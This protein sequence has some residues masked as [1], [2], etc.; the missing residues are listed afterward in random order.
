MSIYF[1][2]SKETLK[3]KEEKLNIE[4]ERDNQMRRIETDL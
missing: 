4:L 1:M 2:K 3:V